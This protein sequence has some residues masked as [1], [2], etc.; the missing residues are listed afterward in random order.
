VYDFSSSSGYATNAQESR[1]LLIDV[2]VTV[3]KHKVVPLKLS[4]SYAIAERKRHWE[5]A[6]VDAGYKLAKQVV[7][8]A[9]ELVDSNNFSHVKVE[10]AANCDLDTISDIVEIMNTNG[11]A[12]LGR[13]G[14]INSSVANSLRQITGL[15]SGDFYGQIQRGSY[16]VFRGVAGFDLYEYPDL[17]TDENLIGFFCDPRAIVIAGGVPN[18]SV[19][20]AAELN[21]PNPSRMETLTDPDT[22]ITMMLIEWFDPK[23]QDIFSAVTMLYGVAGGKQGVAETGDTRTDKAAVRLISS[24]VS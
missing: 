17:S 2:D 4:H 8:D 12:D 10:T 22:G 3:N 21:L 16:T 6:I 13:V 14:I 5:K 24:S 11:A 1:A 23:F 7:D 9:L 20:I 18:H 15:I 19:D